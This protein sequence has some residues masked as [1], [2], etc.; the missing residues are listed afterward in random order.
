MC[1]YATCELGSRVGSASL[2]PDEG[3][4]ERKEVAERSSRAFRGGGR[5][6]LRETCQNDNLNVSVNMY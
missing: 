4:G 2:R 3:S 5:D 6:A 1:Q